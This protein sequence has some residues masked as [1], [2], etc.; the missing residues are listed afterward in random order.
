MLF[1]LLEKYNLE[2]SIGNALGLFT[3]VLKNKREN[4]L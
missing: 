2:R 4:G 1:S 3:L